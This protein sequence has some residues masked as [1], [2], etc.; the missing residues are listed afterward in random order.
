[1]PILLSLV[2]RNPIN[3]YDGLFACAGAGPLLD[4]TYD[5]YYPTRKRTKPYVNLPRSDLAGIWGRREKRP[6]LN[7]ELS[8]LYHWPQT[9][10]G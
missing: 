9:S 4:E 10:R 5:I 6:H 7:S 1:M 3:E 8:T 2:A